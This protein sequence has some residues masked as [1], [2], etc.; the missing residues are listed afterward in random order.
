MVR[1]MRAMPVPMSRSANT[2]TTPP[3]NVSTARCA[4]GASFWVT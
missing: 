2:S 1:C 4:R 3:A